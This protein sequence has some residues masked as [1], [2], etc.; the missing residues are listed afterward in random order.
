MSQSDLGSSAFTCFHDQD[1]PSRALPC[2]SAG[3]DGRHLLDDQAVAVPGRLAKNVGPSGPARLGGSRIHYP[4][5]EG[6]SLMA[7]KKHGVIIETPTEARQAEPGPSVLLLLT[8][9]LVFVVLGM[10]VVWYVF[11]RT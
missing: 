10:T 2:G 3:R 11:F 7:K 6:S 5:D 4:K 8:V 9:S 1:R